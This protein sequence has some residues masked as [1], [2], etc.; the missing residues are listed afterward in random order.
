MLALSRTIRAVGAVMSISSISSNISATQAAVCCC[1][2]ERR[3][4]DIDSERGVRGVLR[5][6]VDCGLCTVDCGIAVLPVYLPSACLPAYM[7]PALCGTVRYGTVR[8]NERV[9]W[10]SISGFAIE[11]ADGSYAHGVSWCCAHMVDLHSLHKSRPPSTSVHKTDAHAHTMHAY[12]SAAK[13]CS[14]GF[15][16]R[17]SLCQIRHTR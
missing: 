15:S 4:R 2:Y 6:T 1:R 12:T 8:G 5:W 10:C 16:L 3:K 14:L 9:C 13:G 7:R 11:F 17:H